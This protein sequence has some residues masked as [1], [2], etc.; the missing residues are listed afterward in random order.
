MG[1]EHVDE[2]T[3]DGARSI[4]QMAVEADDPQRVIFSEYHGSASPSGAFMLRRWPYKL[5]YYVGFEPELFDLEIDPEER[6]NL[7]GQATHKSVVIYLE[8]ELRKICDPEEVDRMA[9]ADQVAKIEQHGGREALEKRGWLQ[10]TPPPGVAP[11]PM[12]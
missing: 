6:N 8:A 9:K 12:N 11:E 3:A 1:I 5:I 2:D 10:G 7:A 4:W